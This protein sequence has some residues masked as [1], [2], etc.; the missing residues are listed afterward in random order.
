MIC[1]CCKSDK[2]FFVGTNVPDCSVGVYKCFGSCGK[3]FTK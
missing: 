3:L 2:V 1:P